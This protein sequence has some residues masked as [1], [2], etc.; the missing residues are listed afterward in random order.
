[1]VLIMQACPLG[2]TQQA[3]LHPVASQGSRIHASEERSALQPHVGQRPGG[4]ADLCSGPGCCAELLLNTLGHVTKGL[5]LQYLIA[6]CSLQ[7][8]Q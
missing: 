7:P 3:G 2:S 4:G 1:M 6:A 5:R 8:Q